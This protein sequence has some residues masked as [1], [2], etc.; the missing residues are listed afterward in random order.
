LAKGIEVFEQ[1]VFLYEV[2]KEEPEAVKG[3]D[4]AIDNDTVKSFQSAVDFS[5]EMF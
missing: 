2:V 1:N 5:I 3:L 4:I